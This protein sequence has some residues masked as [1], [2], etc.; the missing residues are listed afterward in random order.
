M[1]ENNALRKSKE[2]QSLSPLAKSP[3]KQ[4]PIRVKPDRIK[5]QRINSRSLL[6]LSRWLNENANEFV[7]RLN[8]IVLLNWYWPPTDLTRKN[9]CLMEFSTNLLPTVK[10]TKRAAQNLWKDWLEGRVALSLSTEIRVQ[11][12]PTQWVCL[13]SWQPILKGLSHTLFIKFLT[14]RQTIRSHWAF[15]KC[16][17]K[18]STICCRWRRKN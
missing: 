8:G 18:K 3:S 7:D 16:T 4:T 17:W 11:A 2:N 5:V 6:G 10:S 12:K 14:N 9:T 15:A 1:K 13:R